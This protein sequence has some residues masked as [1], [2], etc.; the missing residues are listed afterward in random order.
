MGLKNNAMHAML[1]NPDLAPFKVIQRSCQIQ[2]WTLIDHLV[3]I[4]KVEERDYVVHE[5]ET[6]IMRMARR[7]AS[8]YIS[9]KQGT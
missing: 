7:L 5:P 1:A 3:N 4:Y 6:S 8:G 9:E 2:D